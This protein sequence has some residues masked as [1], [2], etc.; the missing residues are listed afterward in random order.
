MVMADAEAS[1]WLTS[2]ASSSQDTPLKLTS[3]GRKVLSRPLFEKR[4]SSGPTPP[5]RLPTK[6]QGNHRPSF[7]RANRTHGE[8]GGFEMPIPGGVQV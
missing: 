7:P 2:S 1:L 6:G 4:A 5:R 3:P 8:K